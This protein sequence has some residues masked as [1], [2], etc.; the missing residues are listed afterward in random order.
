MKTKKWSIHTE[1]KN[2]L[3]R[4]HSKNHFYEIIE[5]ERK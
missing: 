5:R 4:K 2:G 1:L 3:K